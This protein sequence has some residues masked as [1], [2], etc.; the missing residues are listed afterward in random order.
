MRDL[1]HFAIE[2]AMHVEEITLLLWVD[3]NELDRTIII[4]NRKHPRQ[5]QGND[6]EVPLLGCA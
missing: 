3:L 6:Q 1:I 4:R 2:S 5:K